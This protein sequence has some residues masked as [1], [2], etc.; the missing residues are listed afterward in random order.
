MRGTPASELHLFGKCLALV[1]NRDK[2]VLLGASLIQVLLS[3]LDL[4]GIALI[5]VIGALSVSGV[6]SGSPGNRVSW[7]LNVFGISN[8]AFQFQIAILG[9]SA[10]TLLVIR[11]LLS[12]YF[13]RKTLSFLSRKGAQITSK[14]I[15]QLFSNSLLK[16][17]ERSLQNTIY[18][19]TDG[20]NSIS[21][22]ILGTFV[23]LVSDIALLVVISA[24]LL[25]IDPVVAIFTMVVFGITG[26][27]G[28]KKMQNK[29]RLLGE[30]NS[31]ATVESN[32]K[33]SD[34]IH[35]YRESIVQ[36]SRNRYIE[37]I[38][39]VRFR[40]SNNLAE[41][42]FMPYV[43][44]YLLEAV[45]VIGSFL[46]AALQFIRQDASHAVAT[47]SIF[48]AAGTRIAPSILR[49]Q[50]GAVQV[51]TSIGLS[52][53][54]FE[55]MESLKFP[56]SENLHSHREQLRSEFIPKI[57]IIDVSLKYPGSQSFALKNVSLEIKPGQSVAL[58]GPSGSGKT[59]LADILIGAINPSSGKVLIS[60]LNPR[61]II[62]QWPG[63]V[64]YVPQEIHIIAGNLRE[65]LILRSTV[66]QDME[67]K[68]WSALKMANLDI[69][70]R[71]LPNGLDTNI[72]D[73][74]IR[75]SGGQRQRLGIAR[76]LLTDPKLLVLDEATSAL[77][78]E[79]ENQI[80][81]AIENLIGKVTLIS[82][83]HRLS[84]VQ[85]ADLVCYMK[86][87]EIVAKGTFAEVR[88]RVPDFER[89]ASLMGID[90]SDEKR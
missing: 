36:N 20:V 40:I 6:A 74:G 68:C 28:F 8:F 51:K 26:L 4:A 48:L 69:F 79:T 88:K 2:K 87:G 80:S 81:T 24:G 19:L 63:A 27:L 71:I 35:T 21:M 56:D 13:T 70:A 90:S 73:S 50:Q 66:K 11:T 3:F 17:Q 89:Q 65:N 5:G 15:N 7:F 76:A 32:Q 39:S 44:K 59:S 31:K 67:D 18:A 14:L 22:G 83:A 42:Q 82:I 61:E 43:S 57:Q 85:K 29:A 41:L 58:V 64:S 33:I 12:L 54:T 9:F 10:T 30:V 47:L 38:S 16:I 1:S 53:V 72:S 60:G 46:V 62:A 49:V 77:D 52:E 84:T 75:F 34:L 37:D 45:V 78:S 55:L 86:D 25:F 23:L